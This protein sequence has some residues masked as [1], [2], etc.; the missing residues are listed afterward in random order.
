[1]PLQKIGTIDE[2]RSRVQAQGAL[3]DDHK[4]HRDDFRGRLIWGD[5]K[6]AIATLI[7]ELQ[8]VK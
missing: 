2:P 4:A 6:L 8:F 1:M 7:E 5:N 3:F